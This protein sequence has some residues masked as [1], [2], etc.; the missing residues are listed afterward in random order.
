M[1][2]KFSNKLTIEDLREFPIW[3]FTGKHEYV[4]PDGE[5]V[6]VPVTNLP[7]TTLE[8]RFV[9]TRVKLANGNYVLAVLLGINL[10]KAK[11]VSAAIFYHGEEKFM[12][13]RSAPRVSGPE[14]LALFLGFRVEEVFP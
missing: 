1:S 12:F 5:L 13:R 8:G 2:L 14:Q 11:P 3:E 7:V 4:G 9:G 10:V 6:V